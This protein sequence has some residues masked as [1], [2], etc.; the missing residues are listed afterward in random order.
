MQKLASLRGADFLQD[1]DRADHANFFRGKDGFVEAVE[2]TLET[3]LGFQ[4]GLT[5]LRLAKGRT[6]HVAELFE[7]GRRLDADGKFLVVQFPDQ[8][9]NVGGVGLRSRR[10]L[11][12][13]AQN[14]EH[15]SG[16][17]IIPVIS[18]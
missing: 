4:G 2:E 3:A 10:R 6:R 14:L 7:S 13:L 1:L 11:E 15:S 8:A 9:F 17:P 18:S 5:E 12:M 16:E